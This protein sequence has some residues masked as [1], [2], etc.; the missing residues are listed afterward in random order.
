MNSGISSRQG[1]HQRARSGM[2]GRPREAIHGH[3]LSVRRSAGREQG[4][5][6]DVFGSV[7][8]RRQRRGKGSGRITDHGATLSVRRVRGA[9]SS[10]P[11][12]PVGARQPAKDALDSAK[13][14]HRR[15][16]ETRRN[17]T[18]RFDS[19]PAAAS[20][21]PAYASF[22]AAGRPRVGFVQAWHE[23][24]GHFPDHS[25]ENHHG[26][27]PSALQGQ[28]RR[29]PQVPDFGRGNSSSSPPTS[30]AASSTTCARA[31]TA[32]SRSPRTAWPT[33]RPRDRGLRQRRPCARRTTTCT[34]PWQSV[35]VAA[36]VAFLLDLLVSRR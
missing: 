29:R 3:R 16:A 17:R 10:H 20:A 28:D 32:A 13:Q 1:A 26:N 33:P 5:G 23:A 24:S 30:R 8:G 11:T 15:A 21:H 19:A 35:G 36:S 18:S 12:V 34:K 31:S 27:D 14:R 2:S 9:S 4:R 7:D 25:R 6:V 22:I